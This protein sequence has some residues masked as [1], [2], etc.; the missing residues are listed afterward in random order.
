MRNLEEMLQM[1]K[2]ELLD[3]TKISKNMEKNMHQVEKYLENIRFQSNMLLTLIQ[4]LLDLAKFETM[5]FTFNKEYF[6]MNELINKAYETVR[7]QASL[8]NV[9]IIKEYLVKISD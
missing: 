5:N 7:H 4:D 1:S 8:K 3:I 9:R 2:K 6:N